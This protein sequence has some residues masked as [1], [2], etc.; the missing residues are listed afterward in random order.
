MSKHTKA[1]LILFVFAT[2]FWILCIIAEPANLELISAL[3]AVFCSISLICF[4]SVCVSQRISRHISPYRVF[5]LV[6]GLI[7]L[8]AVVCASHNILTDTGFFA[9][10]AGVVLLVT[11]LPMTLLLL[12]ADFLAFHINQNRKK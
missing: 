7:G 9:G 12:L 2:F 11:V 8:C 3:A 5:A 1:T 6:D 10:I 4:L